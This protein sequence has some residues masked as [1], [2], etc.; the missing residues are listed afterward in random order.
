MSTAATETL[1][2][3]LTSSFCNAQGHLS[4]HCHLPLDRQR[5]ALFRS[6][7]F[8]LALSHICQSFREQIEWPRQNLK[9]SNL[10]VLRLRLSQ[11][12]AG[13]ILFRFQACLC[14]SFLQLPSYLLLVVCRRFFQ[15]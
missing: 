4:R 10:G 6:A 13:R 7:L 8:R 14:M 15:I 1:L 11:A 12:L 2:S 9:S 3:Y 5:E